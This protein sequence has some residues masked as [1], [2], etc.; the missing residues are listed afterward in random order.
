MSS[1][2]IILWIVVGIFALFICKRFIE[3]WF[4]NEYD[5]YEEYEDEKKEYL[6]VQENILNSVSTI[7][8]NKKVVEK[9]STIH[10]HYKTENHYHV[11]NDSGRVRRERVVNPK[12]LLGSDI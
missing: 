5:E 9:S 12:K 6:H 10:N 8:E 3:S 1:I 2:E 11:Y 7:P 4:N